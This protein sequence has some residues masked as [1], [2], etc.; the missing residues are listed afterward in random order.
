M[1]P[2]ILSNLQIRVRQVA[3]HGQRSTDIILSHSGWQVAG[4]VCLMLDWTLPLPSFLFRESFLSFCKDQLVTY[5]L[6]EAWPPRPQPTSVVP[7]IFK[8]KSTLSLISLFLSILGISVI[9][10]SPWQITLS[11]PS[12]S[13]GL[14]STI[15]NAHVTLHVRAIFLDV[16]HVQCPLRLL[17]NYDHT[18]CRQGVNSLDN[19]CSLAPKYFLLVNCAISL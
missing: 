6:L 18:E 14:C 1:E 3:R 9:P 15:P 11:F 2:I 12:E 16:L 8:I 7:R 19:D 4:E 5:K 17:S 10:L 13:I